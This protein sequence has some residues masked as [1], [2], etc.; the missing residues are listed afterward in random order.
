MLSLAK[1][2][3]GREVTRNLSSPRHREAAAIAR[4]TLA[5]EV[6]S[7]PKLSRRQPSSISA[8]AVLDLNLFQVVT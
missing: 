1:K 4:E 3:W 6:D 5:S 8:D 7:A 2:S